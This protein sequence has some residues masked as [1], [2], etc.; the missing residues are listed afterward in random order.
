[1]DH[2][3]ESFTTAPLWAQIFLLFFALTAV[4]MMVEPSIRKRRFFRQFDAIALGL[5]RQPPRRHAWPVMV[6]VSIGERAFEVRHDYRAS[7]KGTSYRGPTGYLLVT[8]TRLRGERWPMHQIDIR[9][10]GRLSWLTSGKRLTGDTDFD[11][12]FLVVED[13]LPVRDGWLDANV[14]Q[15][16]TRFLGEAP[17]EGVLSVREGELLFTMS[18]PWTGI[19]GPAVRAILE[20]QVALASALERTAA[21]RAGK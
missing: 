14:R 13:G 11:A 12:R 10:L 15:E 3:V 19:D 17:I 6:P 18:N 7:G 9:A 1:M 5:G 21:A 2:L 8:A 16:I 20:R 4:V